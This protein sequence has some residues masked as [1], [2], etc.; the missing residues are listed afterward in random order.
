MISWPNWSP[1]GETLVF[2]GGPAWD[3][4]GLYTMGVGGAGLR[5]IRT[6]SGNYACAS[7]SPDGRRIATAA[8]S[9]TGLSRV[10]EIDLATTKPVV[11]AST[12]SSVLGCPEWSPNDK[13]LLVSV[14]PNGTVDRAHLAILDRA[15]RVLVS[16]STGPGVS[17]H[18]R[19]D[20]TG[21]WIVFQR[22]I[23]PS[24][25]TD[26]VQRRRFFNNLEIYVI[27]P[28]GTGLR[29]LTSNDYFDAHP[30]W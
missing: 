5:R 14:Y 16:L 20:R 22:S 13:S 10:V 24:S 1:D 23:E 12:D 11:V 2:G 4:L 27:R 25:E 15:T 17:N 28:N 3:S 6:D 8:T 21:S 18:P 30:S 19:W 26:S 9:A 29:R 7:F